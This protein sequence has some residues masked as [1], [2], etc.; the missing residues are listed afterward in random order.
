MLSNF[1][2]V[3]YDTQRYPFQ[4]VLASQVF[5]VPHIDQLHKVWLKQTG[6]VS[7]TYQDN[8][9]LR[10]LMQNMADDSLFYKLYH[11]WIAEVLA[12][13]YA[14]KIS[15]SAHPKMRVHLAATGTVSDFHR[16][17]EVTGRQD[18]INC[19]L[20]FTNVY[21]TCTLWCET[22]YGS[23]NY[24]PLNLR[25]GEALL[26]DGGWLK[27]GTYH[28]ATN[29][30]RVSCDFRFTPTRPALVES[31]WAEVLLKRPEKFIT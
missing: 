6:R 31:P 9:T 5:K 17:A 16:D 29:L 14:S 25:Y 7:L 24:F 12:P 10:S 4:Q 28:N 15:Y 2:I 1:I 20:P 21:D 13:H 11:S 26:W 3:S 22:D 27:H 8:L 18:Q 19:Y 30:T 23:E